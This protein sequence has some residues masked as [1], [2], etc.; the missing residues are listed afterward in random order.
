MKRMIA[1]ALFLASLIT[2]GRASAQDHLVQATIPFDFTVS[3]KLLPSGTYLISSS[4]YT[5]NV[6]EFR[7]PQKNVGAL[8]GVYASGEESKDSKLVF[9]K[10]GD[11]YFLSKIL[12]SNAEMKME[13]PTSKLEKK[14]RSQEAQLH[15]NDQ[16]FVALK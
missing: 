11:R 10:Y 15:R 14:V 3:G 9:N 13:I 4:T 1:I 2:A 5:P 8:S 16:T 7:N 12:C 6:V